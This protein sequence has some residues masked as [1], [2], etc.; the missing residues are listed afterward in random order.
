MFRYTLHYGILVYI[1]KNEREKNEP[2]ATHDRENI[3]I[4]FERN[5]IARKGIVSND[6]RADCGDHIV[7]SRYSHVWHTFFTDCI[8]VIL[9]SLS[10]CCGFHISVCCCEPFRCRCNDGWATA[11]KFDILQHFSMQ[12]LDIYLYRYFTCSLCCTDMHTDT[13]QTAVE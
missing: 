7:S 13:H 8:S 12:R 5:V 11:G 4:K 3:R 6:S 2:P 9:G 1:R 10:F